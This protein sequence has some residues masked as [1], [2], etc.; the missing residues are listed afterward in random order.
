MKRL[1]SCLQIK[2]GPPGG[3]DRRKKS[4]PLTATILRPERRA[5]RWIFIRIK[6][7][8]G[9]I[10]TP[11]AAPRRIPVDD[12]ADRIPDDE[13]ILWPQIAVD[14]IVTSQ[15]HALLIG[16]Q[17]GEPLKHC[18]GCRADPRTCYTS[19]NSP[20]TSVLTKP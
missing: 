20:T 10:Q 16:N 9:E 18:S 11:V 14:D 2:K 4:R 12:A 7:Q 5:N 17:A 15:R 13:H 3:G 6:E 8:F 19:P 1:V